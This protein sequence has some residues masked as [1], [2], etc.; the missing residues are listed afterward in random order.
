MGKVENV[1]VTKDDIKL[2]GGTTFKND[3]GNACFICDSETSNIETIFLR[4]ILMC[5]GD[6]YKIV[7]REDFY[8]GLGDDE[9]ASILIT[10]NLPFE[11]YNSL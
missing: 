1:Y 3:E 9:M 6:E 8:W 4:S 10:T 5:F 11:L 7:S 2:I